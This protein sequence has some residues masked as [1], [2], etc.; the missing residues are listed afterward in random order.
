M[1]ESASTPAPSLRLN[2]LRERRVAIV[3][4]LSSIDPN[5]PPK[6]R[7]ADTGWLQARDGAVGVGLTFLASLAEG[8]DGGKAHGQ[9]S[10]HC[11]AFSVP[12][13]P[14]RIERPVDI[15]QAIALRTQRF[16]LRPAPIVDVEF[17]PRIGG[18]DFGDFAQAFGHRSGGQQRIVALPQIVVIDVEIEREQVD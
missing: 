16:A 7:G 13:F 11:G 17:K 8:L 2:S 14:E 6:N 9:Q 5:T 12:T 10:Y 1:P 15:N 4:P 3:P 18:K